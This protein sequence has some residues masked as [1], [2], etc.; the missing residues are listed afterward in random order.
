MSSGEFD[1]AVPGPA[2]VDGVGDHS[3]TFHR[4]VDGTDL[5]VVDLVEG[6]S[7]TVETGG[8]AEPTAADAEDLL[9]PVDA[10]A[11]VHTDVLRFPG[12]PAVYVRDADGGMLANPTPGDTC[13]FDAGEY[14]LEVC[15]PIKLY[16]RVTGPLTVTTTSDTT[17]VEFGA[18]RRVVVGG[19][20]KHDSPAATVTT[21]TDPEDVMAAVSTFGSALQATSPE[22]SFPS[23]RGHPP[24]VELGDK[25]SVPDAVAP[26]DTGVTIQVP[27][28]RRYVY[29]VAPLAHYLGAEVVPG[30]TPRLVTDAGVEHDLAPD[31]AF[32]REV[33][34]VLKGTFLLDCVVRTEGLYEIGLEE[35]HVVERAVD[36]DL[37]A[38]YDQPLAERL[39][40]YLSVP[41]EAVAPAMPDWKLTAYVEP[42]GATVAALPFLVNDLAVVRIDPAA[43]TEDDVAS[44]GDSIQQAVVDDLFP[45]GSDTVESSGPD[46]PVDDTGEMEVAWVGDGAPRGASKVTAEAYRNR[47]DRSPLEGDIGVTVVC[48]DPEMVDERDLVDGVYGRSDA[49]IEVTRRERLS[50]TELAAVL[51]DD[52]AFLHY[53]GHV[54]GDGFRCTDGRLDATTLDSVGVESF[55]L[56]ACDSYRQG[57]AL[58]EAGAVGG[59]V[60][61]REVVDDSAVQ[62]GST[63]ARL[64]NNGYPL[65]P[66]LEIARHASYVGDDYVVVGDGTVS[67]AKPSVT[68]VD[69]YRLPLEGEKPSLE[70]RSYGNVNGG[71]GTMESPNIAD[72]E[73]Y[74]LV[75]GTLDEFTID[76][77]EDLLSFLQLKDVPVL[78]GGTLHWS[79]ELEAEDLPDWPVT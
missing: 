66:A 33:E 51:A 75:P 39:G 12:S 71:M 55:L 49:S 17:R 11:W 13:T 47:L 22:R 57:M 61:L 53:I 52:T 45:G 31:G 58:I 19:R 23:L 10:A 68:G 28:D 20:S 35:R 7:Y 38:L 27:R 46:L 44:G 9:F 15:P 73:R 77:A 74:Y 65:R 3:I 4:S 14:Y 24:L 36:L 37:A 25:L 30:G 69:L 6:R 50:T 26:P 63:F 16:V 29:P 56:N 41:Y 54:D 21:T 59:V 72:N 32:E 78:I 1:P 5:A 70:F 2:D 60:T 76:R 42:T 79:T 18:P 43:V 40:S 34:R 64:L 48:N 8:P 67:V 62:V